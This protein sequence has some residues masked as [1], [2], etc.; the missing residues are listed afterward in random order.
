MKRMTLSISAKLKRRPDGSQEVVVPDGFVLWRLGQRI[1]FQAT[2]GR[3]VVSPKPQ[4]C[5]GS[6]RHSRRV[7]RGMRSLLK[8]RMR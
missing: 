1:W 6:R 2:R 3:I 8:D 5:R 7:R 4:G